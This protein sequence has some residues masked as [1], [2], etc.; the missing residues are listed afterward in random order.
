MRGRSCNLL[1]GRMSGRRLRRDVAFRATK[2]DLNTQMSIGGI[3]IIPTN[4]DGII[5]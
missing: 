1:A 5:L 3:W 4:H 2:R